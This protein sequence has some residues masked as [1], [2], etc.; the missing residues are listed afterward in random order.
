MSNDLVT[1]TIRKTLDLTQTKEISKVD[2]DKE[3]STNLKDGSVTVT[4]SAVNK[5]RQLVVM[6]KQVRMTPIGKHIWQMSDMQDW[7]ESEVIIG[8]NIFAT[9]IVLETEDGEKYVN[10]SEVDPEPIEGRI[11]LAHL[12]FALSEVDKVKGRRNQ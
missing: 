4:I 6:P 9:I 10:F 1:T 11:I 8:E 3:L 7:D 12:V 5:N 2:M